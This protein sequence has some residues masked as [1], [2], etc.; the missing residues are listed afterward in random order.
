MIYLVRKQFHQDDEPCYT[1]AKLSPGKIEFLADS[2]DGTVWWTTWRFVIPMLLKD[3]GVPKTPP[4]VS[5]E[6]VPDII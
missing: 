5:W 6:D 2:N 3:S 4:I 1:L